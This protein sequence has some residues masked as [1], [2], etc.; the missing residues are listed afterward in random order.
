LTGNLVAKKFG[1]NTADT[2]QAQ[3]RKMK[4]KFN[5]IHSDMKTVLSPSKAHTSSSKVIKPVNHRSPARATKLKPLPSELEMLALPS[6]Q[7]SEL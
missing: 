1:Y 6:K 2:A 4:R 3:F 7:L 5:S